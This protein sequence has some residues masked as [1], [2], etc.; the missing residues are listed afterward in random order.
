MKVVNIGTKER[1]IMAPEA[2]TEPANTPKSRQFW[3][4]VA[5]G[6]IIL[7]EEAISRL[8]ES[9]LGSDNGRTKGRN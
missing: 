7:S 8:L 3:N 6:S 1:P 5:S 2:A 9:D 4:G